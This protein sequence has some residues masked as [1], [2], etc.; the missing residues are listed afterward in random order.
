MLQVTLQKFILVK[1][2][3]HRKGPGMFIGSTECLVWLGH[4][5]ASSALDL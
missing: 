4:L 5:A 3:I 1:N 2:G